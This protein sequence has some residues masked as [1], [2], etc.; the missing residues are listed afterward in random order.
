MEKKKLVSLQALRAL[1]FICVFL[2]HAGVKFIGRAGYFGV[3]VFFILSGFLLTMLYL[4][5]DRDLE[6]S[7]KSNF[8]FAISKIKKLYLLHIVTMLIAIPIRAAESGEICFDLG[9]FRDL[10]RHTFLLQSWYPNI[11]V[12]FAL[13]G[14]DWYLSTCLLQYLLFPFIYRIIKGY[15]NLVQPVVISLLLFAMQAALTSASCFFPWN[16]AYEGDTFVAWFSYIFPVSRLVDFAIGC[17]VGFIFL[18]CRDELRSKKDAMFSVLEFLLG[19]ILLAALV[20]YNADFIR[21][22]EWARTTIWTIPA[23]MSVILFVLNK[24]IFTKLLTN[25]VL[26]YIGNISAVTY[27]VHQLVIK[28]VGFYTKDIG[29][30]NYSKNPIVVAAAFILTVAVSQLWISVNKRIKLRDTSRG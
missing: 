12:A 15:K 27:L 2:M 30:K 10:F 4:E 14:V 29:G 5:S 17:N 9:F 22:M 11:D 8:G 19:C 21:K 26:V 28:V 25:M 6:C 20:L 24:G 7:L 16:A 18:K 1:A 23:C 13:N 3:T